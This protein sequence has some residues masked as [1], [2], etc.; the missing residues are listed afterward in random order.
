MKSVLRWSLLLIGLLVL[1]LPWTAIQAQDGVDE[2]R[3]AVEN[4]LLPA[5]VLRDVPLDQQTMTLED[6]L[7]FYEIPGVSIAVI[8]NGVIDW[9]QGYGLAEAGSNRPVTTDTLFQA[10]S[11]SKPVGATLA[12]AL[13]DQGTLSL[14]TDVNAYLVS[15]KVPQNALTENNPVTLRRL[16]THTA[17]MTVHGFAGYAEGEPVPALVQVLDGTPPA[18]NE[19]IQVDLRPGSQWRYSGGGYTV[20][21]M[22]VQDVTGESFPDLMRARVLDPIG[23]D[24]ST[25]EQPLPEAWWDRAASGH[26]QGGI[27]IPGLWHTYPEIAAAGL[28]TTPTDLAKWLIEIRDS[29]RG[30]ANHV[31]TQGMAEAMITTERTNWGLGP[32]A[33]GAGTDRRFGHGGANAG[34]VSDMILFT[35]SGDGVVIM[36]N[37]DY[38]P[39]LLIN[40]I[41]RAVSRAYDWPPVYGSVMRGTVEVDPVLLQAYAGTY[42][43]QGISIQVAAGDNHLV[44]KVPPGLGVG[45]LAFYPTS[46]SHFFEVSMGMELRVVRDN[47]GR[48][49]RLDLSNTPAGTLTFL[50]Q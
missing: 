36:T 43:V 16:L 27:V 44:V 11:I 19:P 41:F 38:I 48:V 47:T 25:Y 17:G 34:F 29:A 32:M 18:N 30:E 40:E 35:E 24:H 12:L 31:L 8:H 1:A 23:M 3:A 14:D 7:A 46:D 37:S 39:Q 21:Q 9:A 10:G 49:V 13:V 42:S 4:G 20:M 5:L 15:W 33:T 28:W 2:R 22:M 50:P 26:T 45:D 6:R